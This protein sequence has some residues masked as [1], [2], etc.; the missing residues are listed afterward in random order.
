MLLDQREGQMAHSFVKWDHAK[1]VL[2][3]QVDDCRVKTRSAPTHE[4]YVKRVC[5]NA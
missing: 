3:L 5:L 1:A 2:Q 4:D